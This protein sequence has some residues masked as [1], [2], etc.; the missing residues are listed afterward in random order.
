ML[1]LFSVLKYIMRKLIYLFLVLLTFPSCE[2]G[3][4]VENNADDK[5]QTEPVE[6]SDS[7]D[8]NLP[9]VDSA[10][11][12]K[13]SVINTL[14]KDTLPVNNKNDNCSVSLAI[15]KGTGWMLGVKGYIVGDCTK[16]S[17]YAELTSPFTHTQSVLIADKKGE[18]D[19]RKIMS[20]CLSS[21]IYLK[22]EINLVDNPANYNRKLYVHGP[23][24]KYLGFIGMKEVW[25]YILE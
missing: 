21:S 5:Q 1:T 9:K 4:V 18:T 24:V 25:D 11:K 19:I 6:P 3:Y 23:T 2:K 22:R 14:P 12:D 20:V 16:S 13:D 15:E 7:E 10:T 8:N 17:S